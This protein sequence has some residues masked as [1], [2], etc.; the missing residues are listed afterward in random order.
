[1]FACICFSLSHWIF[2]FKYWSCAQRLTL[3]L[4]GKNPSSQDT[5]ITAINITMSSLNILLPSLYAWTY[6][7]EV[8]DDDHQKKILL[9]YY[10]STSLNLMLQVTSLVFLSS[11]LWQIKF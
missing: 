11:A 5:K 7:I 4:N 3:L 1:M 10:T 8:A 9:I 2:S 6:T